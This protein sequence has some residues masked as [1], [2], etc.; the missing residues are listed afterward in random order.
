MD[1]DGKNVKRLTNTPGYDGGAFFSPD[2]KRICYRAHH[3]TDPKELAEYRELLGEHLIK[4]GVLDLMVMDADGGN[5]RVVLSNG[6]ANFAP[7]FH[8][9]FGGALL[10][11]APL[12]G[13]VA[14]LGG[15]VRVAA[16]P[17]GVERRMPHAVIAQLH[18][19]LAEHDPALAMSI[20]PA[21]IHQVR[22]VTMV[23]RRR[24]IFDARRHL[25]HVRD[26]V[27][28]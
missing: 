5:P 8:P 18:R 2:S 13:M 25:F 16:G 26:G 11:M 24:V 15:N 4:P 22:R 21:P 1:L 3:P 14:P 23:V 17:R 10:R 12:L 28:V 9:S 7:F 6:K 20:V 19:L 27:V